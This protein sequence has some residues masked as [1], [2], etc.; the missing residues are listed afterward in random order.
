MPTTSFSSKLPQTGTS[1][2]S[3]M[4]ALARE[5]QAINLSQGFP[6]FESDAKLIKLVNRAMMNGKNQY[7]PMMHLLILKYYELNQKN[8]KEEYFSG[9]SKLITYFGVP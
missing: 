4:S 6:D 7:A 8:S 5:H 3:V 9:Q 1:I 2:F